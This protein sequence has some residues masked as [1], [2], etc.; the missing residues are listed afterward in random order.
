MYYVYHQAKREAYQVHS[1]L[2]VDGTGSFVKEASRKKKKKKT[3]G[4]PIA[5][6][7]R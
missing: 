5:L 2:L 1:Q 3:K 6:E 4:V 7:E